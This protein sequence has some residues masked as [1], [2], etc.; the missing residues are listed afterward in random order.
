MKINLLSALFVL[1][2]F[3]GGIAAQTNHADGQFPPNPM[4]KISNDLTAISKSV[5]TLNQNMKVFIDKIGGTSPATDAQQKM[6][7]GLQILNQAEQRLGTLQKLEI[8][9]VE[10]QVPARSRL[11]LVEQELRPESID[12]SVTFAGTT[13][14]DELRESKKRALTTERASLMALISQIESTLQQTSS[15]VREAQLLVTRL[16]KRLLPQIERQMVEIQDNN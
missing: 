14:T 11:I 9:L 13:K 15:E 7:L 4:D 16:R 5:A 12:R 2:V 8:D 3:S 1:V 10:K 6:L